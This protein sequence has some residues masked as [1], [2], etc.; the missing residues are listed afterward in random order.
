MA[1]ERTNYKRSNTMKKNIV[2][3]YRLPTRDKKYTCRCTWAY[4]GRCV[5]TIVNEVDARILRVSYVG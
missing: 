4:L 1:D 3:T 5:D 2:I